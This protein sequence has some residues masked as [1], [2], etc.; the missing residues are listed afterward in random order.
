LVS[1]VTPVYN[2]ERFLEKTVSSVF[3]QVFTNWEL[4]LVDDHS[5][6]KS[7]DFCK[8]LSF[9]DS[10]VRVFRAPQNGGAGIARNLG[11]GKSRGKYIAFLD[12]DDFWH[13]TK[14]GVQISFMEKSQVPFSFSWYRIVDE[15]GKVLRVIRAPKELD[16]KR[17]LLFNRIGTSTVMFNKELSGEISFPSIRKRQD[18][19]LWLNFLKSGHKAYCIQDA[20][21]DYQF[22]EGSLSSKKMG[23]VKYNWEVY[24]NLEKKG[25]A[26]SMFLLGMDVLSKVLR[27]K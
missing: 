6:D 17:E 26:T 3:G 25:I 13:P 1:I 9:S 23:L 16:Y 15:F 4:L 19:A 14:L 24:R 18:Y 2:S 21:T 5:T 11:I 10:R 7:F 27:W 12:S 22:R 8:T 20:L